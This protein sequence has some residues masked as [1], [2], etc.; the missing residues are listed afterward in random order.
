MLTYRYEFIIDYSI[1]DAKKAGFDGV[2]FIIKEENY[3][4]FKE[5]IGKR[6]EPHMEVDYVFQITTSENEL[7][8]LEGE[9]SNEYNLSIIDLGKCEDLLKETNGIN[10]DVSL[11]IL[12]FEN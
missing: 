8:T 9:Y 2:V 5:T 3:E 6:V 1:Y 12:K 11:I 7:N 4:V 10:N